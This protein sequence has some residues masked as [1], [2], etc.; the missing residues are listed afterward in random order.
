MTQADEVALGRIAEGRRARNAVILA[1]SYQRPEVQ[2]VADF[3]GDSLE[4]SR[5]AA[6]ADAD[7]I[8]FCG[9]RFMAESAAI[10]SPSRTVL[11][12]VLEAG[13]PMADM[14]TAAQ[15]REEMGRHPDAVV[16]C[17]VNSDAEVKAE[18][19]I[20]CTSANAVRVVE[21]V[22]ADREVLF[23]P[24]RNLGRY[25]ERRTGRR[26]ILWPG[27][28]ATHSRLT[29]DEVREARAVHPAAVV[30][31]HPECE[32]EVIDEADM[33]LSTSQMVRYVEAE[34]PAEVIVGTEM[35]II[36]RLKAASP[37]T[38]FHIPSS[39][40]ICPT[41]KLTTLE[42]VARALDENVH[43]IEVPSAVRERAVSSLEAMLAVPS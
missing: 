33:A 1:H 20:C 41:M 8:V 31:V 26:M 4:L 10:L 43:V 39:S 6:D 16:V 32:L 34:R 9:V 13:C 12:P 18:S 19:D 28:C 7:V 27:H 21:S 14:I 5:T 2:D 40:L 38:A 24:D 25:V 22:P 23:V 30:M 11:L 17:Y 42:S 37:E 35:G 3:V 29:A 36:H 15:L